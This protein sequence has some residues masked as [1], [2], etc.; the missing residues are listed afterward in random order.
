[1]TDFVLTNENYFSP[2]AQIRYMSASQ[3]KDFEKCEAMALAKISG[4]WQD[5]P[6]KALLVGSYVDAYFSNEMDDFIAKNPGLFNSRTGALKAEYVQAERIIARIEDDPVMMEHLRGDKQCILTGEIEGVPVRIKMDAYLPGVRI[7]DQKIMSSMEPVYQSG[8]GLVPF[9]K[10]WGYDKSMAIYQ[11]I[12][13]QNSKKDKLPCY[14]VVA[15]K[16]EPCDKD[17]IELDQQYLDSALTEI[18]ANIVY[19][20]LIRK[21]KVEPQRCGKCAYCRATKKVKAPVKASVLDEAILL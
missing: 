1:M 16:Q 20:D 21:G 10:A 2:E 6:T 7:S 4:F 18:R 13:A 11:H 14:L 5:E 15:T 19:Y 3:Y 17:V 8:E 9:W 12:E